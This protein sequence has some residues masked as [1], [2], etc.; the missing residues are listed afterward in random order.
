MP[1]TQ[2]YTREPSPLDRPCTGSYGTNNADWSTAGLARAPEVLDALRDEQV[3][4]MRDG[5]A[6][7]WPV[8]CDLL[9]A[10]THK[11]AHALPPG[12]EVRDALLLRFLE[13][14]VNV[15]RAKK[16][17][18][19]FALEE[20]Y[21][22]ASVTD[23]VIEQ[24]PELTCDQAEQIVQ[25]NLALYFARLDEQAKRNAPAGQLDAVDSLAAAQGRT[26]GLQRAANAAADKPD[27]TETS[28]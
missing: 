15:D 26:G 3:P 20:K 1:Y 10:S 8:V 14:A 5:E 24:R 22:L 9:R 18:E 13:P 25:S 23:L 12:D 4:W 2:S 7:L 11:H 28:T 19:L 21:G 16:R 6:Q 17:L 27:P